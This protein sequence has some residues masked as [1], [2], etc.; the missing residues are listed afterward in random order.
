M[1]ETLMLSAA[2]ISV[3]LVTAEDCPLCGSWLSD[4][5]GTLAEVAAS[6]MLSPEEKAEFRNHY[7]GQLRLEFTAHS[8]RSNVDG[9]L[10]K[11]EWWPYT[12]RRDGKGR[13]VVASVGENRRYERTFEFVGAGCVA[14]EQP[15]LGF[16]EHFCRLP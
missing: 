5:P 6:S 12:A 7:F 16:R 10:S 14:I 8:M 15:G 9:E 1:G 4:E 13:V 3:F 2:L 11:A